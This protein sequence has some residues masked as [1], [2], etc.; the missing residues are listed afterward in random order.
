MDTRTGGAQQTIHDLT[1]TPYNSGTNVS[2]GAGL[3]VVGLGSPDISVIHCEIVQSCILADSGARPVVHDVTGN[4]NV[5]NV[6]YLT[7][8]VSSFEGHALVAGG[9]TNSV[10]NALLNET[11]TTD[12]QLYSL[13]APDGTNSQ[14][15][16]ATSASP[17]SVLQTFQKGTTI[18]NAG[19]AVCLLPSSPYSVTDCMNLN[20]AGFMGQANATM[21]AAAAGS[22]VPVYTSGVISIPSSL[23]DGSGQAAANSVCTSLTTNGQYHSATGFNCAGRRVGTVIAAPTGGP[24]LVML[25]TLPIGK[26]YDTP[27]AQTNLALGTQASPIAMFT[28]PFLPGDQDYVFSYYIT[29]VDLGTGCTSASTV[30]VNL[31]FT[32]PVSGIVVNFLQFPVVS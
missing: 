13:S 17:W 2:P 19:D 18:N 32:D 21:G 15:T 4:T 29:Q 20:I 25:N 3:Y 11:V 7:P 23:F 12:A 14:L 10:K 1:L 16:R 6:V 30:T 31:Q 9:A 26:V 5:T 24:V 8:T 28:N 22:N 27:S